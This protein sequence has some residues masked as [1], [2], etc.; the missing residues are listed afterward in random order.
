MQ[1]FAQVPAYLNFIFIE[2]F[3]PYPGFAF[4]L[5]Y[6]CS[7]RVY[8]VILLALSVAIATTLGVFL[9]TLASYNQGGKLDASLTLGALVPFT[10]PV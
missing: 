6:V 7:I 9:G 8:S 10:F 5:D 2:R 3:G 1:V 4:T